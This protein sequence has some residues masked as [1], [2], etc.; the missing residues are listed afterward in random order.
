M[1]AVARIPSFTLVL[2]LLGSLAASA[3]TIQMVR[4]DFPAQ[5]GARGIAAADFNRDGYLD[6]VTAHE[7]PHGIAVH[8]NR[9]SSGG[10]TETFIP[11]TGGPFDVAAGDVNNDGI[12]DIAVANADAHQVN[13]ILGRSDASFA[14]PLNL[15][16]QWNPRAI[17]IA[18]MNRD[19]KADLVF[20]LY[21]TSTVQVLEGSGTGTFTAA[22]APIAVG[23]N[24]QGVVATDF[25]HDG[26]PDLAVAS[27][28][29]SSLT[30][31]H[32]RTDG[33]FAR[34]EVSGSHTL[35]VLVT[36]D[37]NNDGKPDV[38][39]AS[40]SS[41]AV[42]VFLGGA[43]TV[44][45]ANSAVTGASPRGIAVGDLDQ[46]GRLDLATG[47]RASST[48]SVMG[49]LG[50]GTFTAAVDH[51]AGNG[52][53]TVAAGD[54]N[55]D[56]RIDIATGNE[57]DSTTTVLSNATS[58]VRA[59]FAFTRQ[60]VG[61]RTN[62]FSGA[63]T[64]AIGDFDHDGA[65]DLVTH[66]FPRGLLVL[67]GNG[68]QAQ[69]H[70]DRGFGSLEVLD[71]NGDG[72]DD[73]V[74][75]TWEQ[76]PSPRAVVWVL[77]GNGQ[78]QFAAPVT[79]AVEI[80]PRLLPADLNRDG[81]QDLLLFGTSPVDHRTGVVQP[82]L[83]GGDGTFRVLS[84]LYLNGDAG[85][86]EIGDFDRNGTLDFIIGFRDAGRMDVYSGSGSGTFV[87]TA[88]I[89][90][91][92]WNYVITMA[93]GDV[94]EDGYLDIVG[95]TH[96]YQ[97]Q[98]PE[99]FD[100][101]IAVIA[102]GRGGFGAPVYQQG[103]QLFDSQGQAR[104]VD[105][106]M[107]GHLDLMTPAGDLM[108]GDGDGGFGR[109]EGFA[110]AWAIHLK[111]TDYN[112]D[113]TADILHTTSYGSVDV[114]LN[115]R[116]ATNTPPV[117]IAPPDRTYHYH[118]QYGEFALETH[119]EATDPDLHRVTHQWRHAD[120]RPIETSENGWIVLP[121][122][123]P[124]THELVLEVSDGRGGT[125]TDSM[126]VTIL[127]LK[128]I[129]VHMADG[130]AR[131][132]WRMVDDPTAASGKRAYDQNL[133]RA[134]VTTPVP[135]SS[136]FTR[137]GFVADPTQTYKF[138][139]RLKAEGD[140]WANDSLWLQ[141]EGGATDGAGN[142]LGTTSSTRGIEVNLEECSGCGISG[143]GWRDE[144]WG[145]RGAV[146]QLTLRFPKG[147]WQTLH[148]QTREDGVSIDQFVLSAERF[149]TGRPG[150]VKNDTTILPKYPPRDW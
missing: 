39:G 11:L 125:G 110:L 40:T 57:F 122:M 118:E 70:M 12:P 2:V 91:A 94:N 47:N 28:A 33:S 55:N 128:E 5:T 121:Q 65:Y 137:I 127:P 27:N 51:A 26:R 141:F 109:P 142:P 147:G 77:P 115:R 69:L 19:G 68:Q 42:D 17:T 1:R 126:T 20:S 30:I 105:L 116:Q 89:A 46:D 134:K 9:G 106:T 95:T 81:R 102:G 84:A 143:W 149:R 136:S 85:D 3:Q 79:T 74:V 133:G 35:N 18:D 129:V 50:D 150:A 59:G 7:G 54:F 15:P 113:G 43:G 145:Q 10:F 101:Q 56:G 146:G 120:G 14:S 24:P 73:L 99:P 104:L 96:V 6:Y 139:V 97:P 22:L 88:S 78:G 44:A 132:S 38:A 80:S 31:L 148:I 117:A 119:G 75:V 103:P 111:F 32:Q 144:A 66:I 62:T 64:V 114:L 60:I 108:I 93:V 112:H 8:Y 36:A 13:V 124:G 138:W 58:L 131:E 53:R 123:A 63:S 21:Q 98:G 16:A 23:T 41:A 107:D 34:T 67:L 135:N 4:D 61:T 82:L 71:V 45:Y 76:T 100:Y 90:L 29:S 140:H 87:H 37:F 25:N 92:Q 130:W 48:V 52:S 83:G 86:I 72:D 49:G